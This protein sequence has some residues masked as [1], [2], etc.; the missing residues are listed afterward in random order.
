VP[1]ARKMAREL[2]LTLRLSWCD[3][4]APLR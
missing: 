4:A 2:N 1:T 3:K